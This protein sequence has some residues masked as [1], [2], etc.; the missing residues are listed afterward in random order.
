MSATAGIGR[1]NSITIDEAS[2]SV[3]ELP[4]R[5]PTVTP[6]R[7]ANASPSR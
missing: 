4:I 6:I 5:R 7:I 2:S 1:R 3:G